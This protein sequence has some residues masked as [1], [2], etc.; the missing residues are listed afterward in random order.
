MVVEAGEKSSLGAKRM[1]S[2]RL[3]KLVT[4]SAKERPALIEEI[5]ELVWH[6]YTRYKSSQKKLEQIREALDK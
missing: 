2:T 4:A 3:H 6:L 1:I 5:D